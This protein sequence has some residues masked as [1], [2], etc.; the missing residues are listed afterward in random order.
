MQPQLGAARRL[1]AAS[2]ARLLRT[3]ACP[4]LACRLV[5]TGRPRQPLTGALVRRR[6]AV[7]GLPGLEVQHADWAPDLASPFAIAFRSGWA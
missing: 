2:E 6:R 7:R 5:W 1:G 4:T 3:S